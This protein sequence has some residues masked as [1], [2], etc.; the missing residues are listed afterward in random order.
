MTTWQQMIPELKDSDASVLAS[1]FDFSG[2]Q[3]ENIARK[4][5]INSI[6][7]GDSAEVLPILEGYCRCEQLSNNVTR[8]RIG[9]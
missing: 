6:L 4:H 7:Y 8:K 9:F 5:A 1:H 3:I 2:G